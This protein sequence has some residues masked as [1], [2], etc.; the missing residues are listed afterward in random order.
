METVLLAVNGTLMRD[1]E[2]NPNLQAVGA[3]FVRKARTSSHYRLW[4]IED[5][6]PAM[7]RSNRGGAEIHCEVWAV[8]PAG[9]ASVLLREPAGLTIGKVELSDGTEVLGVLAEPW[10]CDNRREITSYGGWREFVA[11]LKSS[12]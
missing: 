12:G 4:S 9:L 5:R 3:T 1:L 6:F 7:L 2:L 10:L 8:P 11:D